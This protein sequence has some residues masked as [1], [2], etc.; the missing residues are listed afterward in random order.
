MAVDRALGTR[1]SPPVRGRGLKHSVRLCI[2]HRRWS[3][4]V[5]G[6]GLKRP[7]DGQWHLDAVAPRAGAWI[8]TGRFPAISPAHAGIGLG[9]L[10][11]YGKRKYVYFH[12]VAGLKLHCFCY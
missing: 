1:A 12:T 7:V 8:D 10:G 3:P 9:V 4:P 11:S 2:C 6:R 5:R